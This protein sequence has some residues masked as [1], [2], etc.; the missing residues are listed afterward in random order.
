M[1][2]EAWVQT[3][4]N[5]EEACKYIEEIPKFTEKNPLCHTR[6]CL[7]ILG[8]PDRLYPSVH[9]AGTNGKGSVCCYLESV[10]RTAG[11]KTALF[12]S[13]HLVSLRERFRIGGLEISEEDFLDVFLRV[14]EASEKMLQAGF[15]HPSYFEFLYL[16]AA[17][18]FSEMKPDL[19]IIETGLGGRL[20]AT[21][22]LEHPLLCVITSISLDH[23]QYL[24][25]TVEKI[26]AEK[27]GILKADVPCVFD[28][29]NPL[30]VR[31]IRQA[32][33][34]KNAEPA[35]LAPEDY[36]I[37]GNTG[38]KIDF[39]T[40]FRYYE[41]ASYTISSGAPYQAENASLAVLAAQVLR[42]KYFGELTE[43]EIQRGIAAA[44]WEGRME[45][46]LP[47][48]FLDGAH[49]E[50]GIRCFTEAVLKISGGRKV[51]LVF[52][53]AADKDYSRMIQ[54]LTGQL[55]LS[56][57]FTTEIPGRRK[58]SAQRFA[59]LFRLGSTCPVEAVTDPAAAL[60]LALEM[61]EDGLLFI[62]GSLYLIG[63]LKE[64]IHDKL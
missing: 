52:G 8:N 41:N 6:R 51:G 36:K 32:A 44:F 16:M 47:G 12:T 30:A 20:D 11:K 4:M 34:K 10:F 50:D 5:Y 25:D 1:G 7:E 19:A 42:K 23:M 64:I 24:G 2:S 59:E 63:A 15:S 45:E 29:A 57:V 33:A 53:A 49:N 17:L 55:P 58:E 40:A 28:A 56:F 54:E 14:R 61:K 31:V 62:C 46:I 43:E 9:V 21:N 35:G 60:G 26:A 13:P 22:T 39:S 27:A 37:S 18:Y 38:R 3:D 48:V